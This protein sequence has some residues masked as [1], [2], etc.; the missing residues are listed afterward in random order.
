MT[1]IASLDVQRRLP[2]WHALSDVFLD[3]ELQARD[4]HRIAKTLDI[5]G[6]SLAELRSIL[7]D[8]VAPAFASN[9]WSVAGEWAGWSENDVQTIMLKSLSRRRL[10]LLSWLKWLVRRRH[11]EREWEKIEQFLEQG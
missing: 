9:L 5:S 3:T 4:H 7:E 1:Q 11:I 6:Y 8:E 2:V 10:P